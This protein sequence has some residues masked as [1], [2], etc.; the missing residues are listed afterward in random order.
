MQ[1]ESFSRLEVEAALCVWECI[2]DWTL[3]MTEGRD[4][5]KALREGVGSAELRYQSVA[6]GKWCLAVFDVCTAHNRDFFD[7]L[8]YDWEVIPM[9]LDCA[10]DHDG[11]PVIY[12]HAYPAVAETMQ[13]VIR[14]TCEDA[15][16]SECRHQARLQWGYADLIS[17]HAERVTAAFEQ[18]ED[19]AEFV[20]WLGEKYDLT[21]AREFA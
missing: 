7:G 20:K 15:W 2:D 21:P 18:G 8:A 12:E 13:A 6:L 1:P 5:W 10:R 9:I 4:D 19:A 14:R 17:D 16:Q 11:L 3:R